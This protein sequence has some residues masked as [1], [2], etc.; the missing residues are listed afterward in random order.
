MLAGALLGTAAAVLVCLVA[1]RL[2][3]P[4]DRA[5]LLAHASLARA[6]VKRCGSGVP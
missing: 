1:A 4:F 3:W 2:P 5:Y 6:M